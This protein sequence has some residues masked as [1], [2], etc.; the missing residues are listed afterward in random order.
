M[1]NSFYCYFVTSNFSFKTE[2]Y[3]FFPNNGSDVLGC[4]AMFIWT[5]TNKL[6]LKILK[7]L[8]KYLSSNMK[9]VILK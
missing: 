1:E 7:Q 9:L 3:G 4:V 6:L 8:F 2:S 5:K